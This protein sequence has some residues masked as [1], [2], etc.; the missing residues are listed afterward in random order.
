[1]RLELD[2]CEPGLQRA[3]TD[4]ADVFRLRL[5]YSSLFNPTVPTIPNTCFGAAEEMTSTK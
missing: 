4:F 5:P 1:M 2:A 3:R